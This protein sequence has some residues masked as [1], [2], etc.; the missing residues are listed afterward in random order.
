MRRSVRR[1]PLPP[2]ASQ[3]AQPPPRRPT[4]PR[5]GN[6]PEVKTQLPRE[7]LHA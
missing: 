7:A 1:R 6:G 2:V 4:S 3:S 5:P